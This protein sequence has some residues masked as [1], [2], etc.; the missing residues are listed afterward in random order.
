M[1]QELL[2]IDGTKAVILPKA[3]YTELERKYGK[4]LTRVCLEVNEDEITVTPDWEES[5]K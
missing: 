2:E 5:G 3:W 1:T 4:E